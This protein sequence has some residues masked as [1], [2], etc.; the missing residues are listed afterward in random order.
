MADH[1]ARQ[2]LFSQEYSIKYKVPLSHLRAKLKQNTK[3]I[4]S[5]KWENSIKARDTH[6]FIPSLPP[7]KHFINLE[8]NH[9]LTQVLTGH[10]RLNMYL[11][12]IGVVENPACRCEEYVETVDHYLFCCKLENT[13]RV[14]TLIKSCFEQGIPFP[15]PKHLLIDNEHIFRALLAFLSA[16]SRLDFD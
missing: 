16:S 14:N 7:P 1:F 2:S 10:C 15:P 13:N 4:L 12:Y 3:T 8:H 11:N 5:H 9:K 6:E